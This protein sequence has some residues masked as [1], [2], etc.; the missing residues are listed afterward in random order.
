MTHLEKRQLRYPET[1]VFHYLNINPKQKITGDCVIRAISSVLNQDWKTTA[2]ELYE[3]SLKT[4]YT[5]N[6]RKNIHKYMESKGWIKLKQPRKKDNTKYTG[7]EFCKKLNEINL[8]TNNRNRILA[9]IGGHHM[10]AII[11]GKVYDSWNSTNG[12][13]GNLYVRK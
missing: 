1:D 7:K 11:A 2:K 6:D 12:C 3:L 5:F 8:P 10:V 9:N 13:I 4:C